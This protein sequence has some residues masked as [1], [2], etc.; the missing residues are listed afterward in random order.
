MLDSLHLWQGACVYF[1]DLA[2][3]ECFQLGEDGACFGAQVGD[4]DAHAGWD[5]WREIGEAAAEFVDGTAPVAALQVIKADADLEDALVEVADVVGL[6]AP[7]RF[8]RLVALP[9]F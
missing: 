3:A 2:G 6:D 4:V 1:A 8:Q 7:D 9:V 5:G